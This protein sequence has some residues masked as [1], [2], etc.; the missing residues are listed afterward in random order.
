MQTNLTGLIVGIFLFC[1]LAIVLT[2]GG[3]WVSLMLRRSCPHCRT[4]ML[5]KASVC[6][7]CGKGVP[8][9]V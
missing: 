5:K 4:M 3:A 2:V 1:L 6:P 7:H 9:A 8:L